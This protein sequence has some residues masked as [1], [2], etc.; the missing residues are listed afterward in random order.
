MKG[1][2]PNNSSAQ[3]ALRGKLMLDVLSYLTITPV[4]VCPCGGPKPSP[5]PVISIALQLDDR[6]LVYTDTIEQIYRTLKGLLVV[7]THMASNQEIIDTIQTALT[8]VPTDISLVTQVFLCRYQ[9]NQH[10]FRVFQPT[11]TLLVQ[12]SA[13]DGELVF[14]G[15]GEPVLVGG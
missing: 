7:G 8:G 14:T 11:P 4:S 3:L 15:G 9:V 1:Y 10:T 13:G 5:E 6:I 2:L 12:L